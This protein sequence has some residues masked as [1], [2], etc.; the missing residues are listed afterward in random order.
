M[1]IL[2]FFIFCCKV[3]YFEVHWCLYQSMM[4]NL[5]L[6]CRLVSPHL[7]QQIATTVMT[8]EVPQRPPHRVT[9]LPHLLPSMP[10]TT[11]PVTA[12]TK[13][14]KKQRMTFQQRQSCESEIHFIVKKDI[15]NMSEGFRCT[16]CP[17][18]GGNVFLEM[19]LFCDVL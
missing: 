3:L 5:F 8:Q 17:H 11:I 7:Q 1:Q 10:C 4:V 19:C 18:C 6:S 2:M 9:R 12:P 16:A 14:R 13:T 15:L